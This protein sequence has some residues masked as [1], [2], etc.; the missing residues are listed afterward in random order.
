MFLGSAEKIEILETQSF[1]NYDWVFMV[2][3]GQFEIR[4][5][6]LESRQKKKKKC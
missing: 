1:R 5:D 6:V 3:G 2:G 4:E